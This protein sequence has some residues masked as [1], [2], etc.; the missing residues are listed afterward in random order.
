M[1]RNEQIN[2]NPPLWTQ[3]Q[4]WCWVIWS[5]SASYFCSTLNNTFIVFTIINSQVKLLYTLSIS[6]NKACSTHGTG[7]QLLKARIQ[8]LH[9]NNALACVSNSHQNGH[10]LLSSENTKLGCL[11]RGDAPAVE[12]QE[13]EVSGLMKPVLR[14]GGE[15]GRCRT[16]VLNR[17]Q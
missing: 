14:S 4:V 11:S 10:R 2:T 9:Q 15:T 3:S 6:D 12:L 16:A 1:S 13:T 5:S 17:S 8:N 7:R